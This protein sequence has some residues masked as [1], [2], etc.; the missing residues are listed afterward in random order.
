[1]PY[2][3][4]TVSDVMAGVL[5]YVYADNLNT[6]KP[7]MQATQSFVISVL[8]R[9]T[10]QSMLADYMGKLNKNQKNQLIVGIASAIASSYK[11]GSPAKAALA[12]M[13]IDLLATDLLNLLNMEDSGFIQMGGADPAV[14]PAKAPP[15]TVYSLPPKGYT[16]GPTQSY[17]DPFM[18]GR[19]S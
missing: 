3:L 13:S 1:M 6:G 17:P 18:R 16:S 9:I 7:S 14:V 11:N 8:A 19:V 12:G 10:S 5:G 15:A 4:I 2:D